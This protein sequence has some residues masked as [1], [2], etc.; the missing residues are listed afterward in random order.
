MNLSSR[1]RITYLMLA[2]FLIVNAALFLALGLRFDFQEIPAKYLSSFYYIAPTY[3]V[4]TIAALFYFR[5]Y[6]RVWEYA[7]LKEMIAIAKATMLSSLIFWIFS[8]M[9]PFYGMPRSVVAISWGLIFLGTSSLR[10]YWR[11]I[12]DEFLRGRNNRN[13][14]RRRALIIGAGDAGALLLKEFKQNQTLETEVVGFIDDDPGKKGRLIMEVPILGKRGGIPRLVKEHNINEIIIAMPSVSGKTIREIVQI[15]RQ[16]PARM[17]ILPSIYDTA[18]N[19]VTSLRDV[20]MEDLLHR[21]AVHL[22]MEKISGY[23][24]GKAVLVTGAGGSIGSELCRQV[25]G[26]A[27]RCLIMVD[28]CENNLFDIEQEIGRPDAGEITIY[29]IVADVK[30]SQKMNR[31]FSRFRPQVVFHAAAYKHVPMMELHPEEALYNNVIG[32]KI[33]A[34]MADKYG[35]ETFILISTDKAVN[36]TSIMGATKRI[37]ELVIKDLNRTSKTALAAVRFGNVLGSRG[38]VIPTFLKQIEAGG[39]VTVTHPDMV[40]Y[41]M[42]I[43]EAVQLVIQAGAMASGGEVFVLDMGEPVR[44]ADLARDLI[45]ITGYQPD[46]EIKIVY[47]GVRPGEKLFEELF[48][49]SEGRLSTQHER[50]FISTKKL[51]EK[52]EGIIDNITIMTQRQINGRKD[53]VRLIAALVPEY[54]RTTQESQTEI[55]VTGEQEPMDQPQSHK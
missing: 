5:L 35:C 8:K 17:R 4:L 42:T 14:T 6:N 24:Q 15:A 13:Q 25:L 54:Q 48:T 53:V 34:E 37:A 27:P 39:P 38:S 52:Y 1:L 18:T 41:F 19:P 28:N 31:I 45:R 16:T 33:T 12:R 20:N 47:T 43:P 9:C 29:T 40:R 11:L 49:N 46:K 2:D 32:T 51:E 21:E 50:I 36:P 23:L 10:L 44:I 55:A 3:A 30:N 7:S 22:H 26:F